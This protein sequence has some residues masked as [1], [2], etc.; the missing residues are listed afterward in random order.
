MNI[1]KFFEIAKAKGIEESQIQIGKSK[2]ISIHLFHH[3][4]DKY[5]VAESQTVKACG[6]YNG[7]FGSATTQKLTPDAFEFLVD[8]I[9]LAATYSEKPNEVGIFK[10][11]EKYHKRDL[12]NKELALI[13]IEKKL[14]VLRE[15]ENAIYDADPRVTDA[16]YVAYSESESMSEFYNSY[17]LKLKQR[18]NSFAFVGSAVCRDGEETKT[19][20]DVFFD[21]DFSKFDKDKFVKGIVDKAVSKFGGEP[22][23]SKKY[24]TVL[25]RDIASSL[26]WAFLESTIADEVQR[27]SSMLKGKL[28]QKV[29]SSKLSI[30][31]KPLAKTM[32]YSYFDDEGV[33]CTNRSIIKNGVLQTYIYNRETAK[34]DGVESTGNGSWE[35][36]KMGTG[37]TQVFVKP[38]KQTF[39]ELIGGIKEGVYITEI[40]GLGTGMNTNSGDFSCQAEGYMI[41]NGKVAEPL[42]LI[43]L[44]GNL[45]KMLS[46]IKGF[47]NNVYM[48]S[49]GMSIADLYIKSMSIGGK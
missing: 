47:D 17:G 16:D 14:G 13:P 19:F 9:I 27:G 20:S 22:C 45:I 26:I 12:Y 3:E 2:S 1:A 40:A 39:D 35:G 6:I 36:A 44:S 7:K 24:P 32:F 28:G 18:R 42:N 43:T 41:R 49:A 8:Q 21:N 31:E 29:A 23:E 37:F 15:V 33:A 10:G 46:D 5:T 34:K 11:S 4:I 48:N 30:E 25:E 38:G